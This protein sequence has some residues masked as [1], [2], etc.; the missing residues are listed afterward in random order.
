MAVREPDQAKLAKLPKWAREHIDNL[1][2]ALQQTE[3][4]LRE[5]LDDQTPSPFSVVDAL[6]GRST[7]SVERYVQGYQ[8][9]VVSGGVRMDVYAVDDGINVFFEDALKEPDGDVAMVPRA[10]NSV[11]L[12]HV[13]LGGR[14]MRKKP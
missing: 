1:D 11:H 5:Y 14:D 8:M 13:R 10:A 4:A 6:C 2:K 3:K 12:R 9:K 7:R